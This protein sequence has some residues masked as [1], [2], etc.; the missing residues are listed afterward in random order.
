M[1][2][3]APGTAGLNQ[4]VGSDRRMSY[5]IILYTPPWYVQYKIDD[6]ITKQTCVYNSRM[7][8]P[9]WRWHV[10]ESDFIENTGN[11]EPRLYRGFLCMKTYLGKLK[12]SDFIMTHNDAMME[13][14]MSSG[15]VGQ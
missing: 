13:F 11:Y 1:A 8:C 5:Y 9:C 7:I 14:Y 10:R 3:V 12:K 15:F 4:R 6:T 2:V